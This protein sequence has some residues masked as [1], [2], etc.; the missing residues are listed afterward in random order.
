MLSCALFPIDFFLCQLQEIL[1]CV[2]NVE[3][4]ADMDVWVEEWCAWQQVKDV[5]LLSVC[6]TEGG[7]LRAG[8]WAG[9]AGSVGGAGS[10]QLWWHKY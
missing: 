4:G 9:G 2:C 8:G 6:L 3:V 10:P 7:A 1:G 5:L